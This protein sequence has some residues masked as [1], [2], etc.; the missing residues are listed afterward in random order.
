MLAQ[1]IHSQGWSVWTLR[2][3][4]QASAGIAAAVYALT[5]PKPWTIIPINAA[6]HATAAVVLLQIIL[7]Y[8]PD[9]RSAIWAVLP[10]VFFPS[11]MTWYTQIEKD[12]YS[13]LGALL[14]CYGWVLLSQINTWQRGWPKIL[15]AVICMLI[16]M[17]LVWIVRPYMMQMIQGLG[18]IMALILICTYLLRAKNKSLFWRQA[19]LVS[20]IV[21]LVVA[22][23]SFF[24]RGGVTI[25]EDNVP[26]GA[27]VGVTRV[28][29]T[30]DH[31]WTS[32]KFIPK[33]V[34]NK[35]YA[36]ADTRDASI[37]AYPDAGS[38]IDSNVHFHS[39]RDLMAYVP[40]ATEIALFAPFPRQWL[41]HGAVM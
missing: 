31:V 26:A 13:I 24:T 16:G 25:V 21:L 3:D 14:I 1:Q 5:V 32:A 19:F 30:N 22:S 18:I 37:A 28:I 15:R 20:L 17:A 35:L 6:L 40:R 11:A 27:S 23:M 12:G 10:F 4:G 9:W 8:V 36:L 39:I 41:Q 34:D 33:F 29:S 7:L 2:P 38:N